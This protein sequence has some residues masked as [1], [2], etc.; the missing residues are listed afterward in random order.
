MEVIRACGKACVVKREFRRAGVLVRQ[1]VAQARLAFGNK[2][3]R[4]AA[5]LHDYGFYLLNIDTINQSVSVY[6][7]IAY[8]YAPAYVVGLVSPRFI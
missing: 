2:H 3:P 1:A 5:A 7:V 4:F 8:T 6:E